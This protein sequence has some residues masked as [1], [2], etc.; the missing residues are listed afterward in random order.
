MVVLMG[1]TNDRLVNLVAENCFL[2]LAFGIS[3][4]ECVGGFYKRP[5]GQVC[6]LKKKISVMELNEDT[7]P[8]S[9]LAANWS[10]VQKQA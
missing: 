5:S 6:L 9:W 7:P 1:F 2:R 10:S 8:N 4:P 3:T